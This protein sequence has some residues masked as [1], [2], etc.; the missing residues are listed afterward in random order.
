M[1]E[2]KLKWTW[3]LLIVLSVVMFTEPVLAAR[4]RGERKGESYYRDRYHVSRPQHRKIFHRIVW[5]SYRRTIY[6]DYGPYW[7]FGYCWPQRPFYSYRRYY[8][9]GWHP[10]RWYGYDPVEYVI[11]RDTYNYH[12]Y[13]YY[14]DS[15]RLKPGEIIGGV[16][17]PDYDALKEVRKKLEKKPPEKPAE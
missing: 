14:Y 15:K 7:T 10:Y 5:P 13:N 17:V 8:W 4:K 3:V 2:S 11:P 9:Y 16:E 6:Y 12:T 1:K